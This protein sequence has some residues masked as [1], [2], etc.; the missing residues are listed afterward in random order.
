MNGRLPARV[1]QLPARVRLAAA[2]EALP[3]ADR[4]VLSLRLLEGLS[5]LETAGATRLTAREVEKR[6]ATALLLLARELGGAAAL[7]RAA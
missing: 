2:L 7:K 3:E 1:R 5:T 4:L 6:M